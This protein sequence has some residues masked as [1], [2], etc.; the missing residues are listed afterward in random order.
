MDGNDNPLIQK[1]LRIAST[2]KTEALLEAL[3]KDIAKAEEVVAALEVGDTQT[4]SIE[5]GEI[6]K[7]EKTEDDC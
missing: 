3:E 5:W 1:F 4:Q 6:N 7:N 2:K